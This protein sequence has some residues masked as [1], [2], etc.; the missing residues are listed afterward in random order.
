MPRMPPHLARLV[1]F[2]SIVIHKTTLCAVPP[3]KPIKAKIDAVLTLVFSIDSSMPRKVSSSQS[4]AGRNSCIARVER[5]STYA[6]ATA[7]YVTKAAK[8]R[9]LPRSAIRLLAKPSIP[10]TPNRTA[11][12]SV[13]H[14]VDITVNSRMPSRELGTMARNQY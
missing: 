10:I 8:K 11:K 7:E 9:L 4:S 6:P 3:A 13:R 14:A 12:A 1:G 5:R 2:D